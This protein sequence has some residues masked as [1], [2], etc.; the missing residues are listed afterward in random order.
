MEAD[1]WQSHHKSSQ[2]L[3][4]A[5]WLS[6][7]LWKIY[8]RAFK[9]IIFNWMHNTDVNFRIAELSNGHWSVHFSSLST[10]AWCSTSKTSHDQWEKQQYFAVSF[11]SFYWILQD[12]GPLILTYDCSQTFCIGFDGLA[13]EKWVIFSP[14]FM[15]FILFLVFELSTCLK[16]IPTSDTLKV[17]SWMFFFF[18]PLVSLRVE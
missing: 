1:Q 10:F 8:Q 13:W 15:H 16:Q 3:F 6:H 5:K 2:I 9:H 7:I 14:C 11:Q 18:V 12:L 17:Q 4:V